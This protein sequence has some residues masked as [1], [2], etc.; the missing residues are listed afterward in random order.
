MGMNFAII[1]S[2]LAF[3]PAHGQQ[4]FPGRHVV[5]VV[6]KEIHKFESLDPNRQAEYDKLDPALYEATLQIQEVLS[7]SEKLKG[8][9]CFALC[10]DAFTSGNTPVITPVL[11]VGE[12]AVFLIAGSDGK[13]YLSSMCGIEGG[14][15]PYIQGRNPDFSMILERLRQRR[16][17]PDLI[18]A[19]EVRTKPPETPQLDL[20][21]RSATYPKHKTPQTAA[22]AVNLEKEDHSQHL[23]SWIVGALLIITTYLFLIKKFRQVRL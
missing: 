15:M 22:Q 8:E 20:S 1:M 4:R 6:V 14:E 19:D 17:H 23:I 11:K 9:E 7:G 3:I 12:V 18:K 2:L 5:L 16:D 10:R 13:I 21:P